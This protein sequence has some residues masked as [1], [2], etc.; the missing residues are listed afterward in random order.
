[1][2]YAMVT[3]SKSAAYPNGNPDGIFWSMV[4]C[5]GCAA[6]STMTYY[7]TGR[8]KKKALTRVAG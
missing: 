3:L 7:L 1:M 2:A 4:I 6:A 8:W 5:F